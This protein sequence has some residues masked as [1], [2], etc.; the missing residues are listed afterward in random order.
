[1]NEEQIYYREDRKYPPR[2][3]TIEG[4]LRMY[5]QH[6]EKSERSATLWHSWS[7]NKRWLSRLLELTLPSCPSYSGHGISHAEAVTQNIERI[8]G[9]RRIRELSAT[10]CFAILH[11]V[12]VHD[13]GMTIMAEDRRRIIESD[14]FTDM[15][16]DL[17][18][19]V[20]EDMKRYAQALQRE[21]YNNKIKEGDLLDLEG[22]AYQKEK[23]HLYLE[24]LD[25]YYAILVGG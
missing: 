21:I 2:E 14:S 13:I 12:Y 23:K 8:L 25:T 17:V 19:G 24:K 22:I 1:M 6:P 5:E 15:V 9:E 16:D 10:D 18:Q 20:D 4:Q 7:Q 3:V 11:V